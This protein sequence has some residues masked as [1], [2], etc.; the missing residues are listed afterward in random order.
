MPEDRIELPETP[1]WVTTPV[2]PPED[3]PSAPDTPAWA[4]GLP[5]VWNPDLGT[6]G[7]W[8]DETG[9]FIRL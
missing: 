3:A 1:S 4:S 7:V 9:D 6:W 5:V 8:N 2:E